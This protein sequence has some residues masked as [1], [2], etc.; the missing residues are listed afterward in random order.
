MQHHSVSACHNKN[1]NQTVRK[2]G[3]KKAKKYKIDQ[4][5]RKLRR[6]VSCSD[7]QQE[8]SCNLHRCKYQR[9]EDNHSNNSFGFSASQTMTNDG[10][11]LVFIGVHSDVWRKIDEAKDQIRAL[12]F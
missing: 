7:I 2:Q 12:L 6:K 10:N 5:L 9:E 3:T 1:L 8:N 11:C 4:D